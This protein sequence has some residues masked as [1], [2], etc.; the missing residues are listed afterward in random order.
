M[1]RERMNIGMDTVLKEDLRIAARDAEMSM[2]AFIRK[3][4]KEKIKRDEK[5]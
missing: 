3:A 1:A 5:C 2:E 4:I